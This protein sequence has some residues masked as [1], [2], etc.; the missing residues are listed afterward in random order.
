MQVDGLAQPPTISD[1][2]IPDHGCTARILGSGADLQVQAGVSLGIS[3]AHPICTPLPTACPRSVHAGIEPAQDHRGPATGEH[4]RPNRR[5]PRSDS[6]EPAPARRT[7]LIMHR[8]PTLSQTEGS[9]TTTVLCCTHLCASLRSGPAGERGMF[10]RCL[11]VRR[12]ITR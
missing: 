4:C 10:A 7:T 8:D 11:L 12:G 9:Q 3:S 1:V 2:R 5:A 6:P